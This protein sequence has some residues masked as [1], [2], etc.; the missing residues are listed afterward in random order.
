[1]SVVLGV[2]CKKDE[3]LLAVARDGELVDSGTLKLKA[4]VLLEETEGL[5]AMLE[6]I[7][8]VVAEVKPDVVRVLLP[9][10]TYE[11]SYKRIAPRASLETLVRLAAHRA[12]VP[13]ELLNR[14]SARARLGMPKSGKFEGHIPST[15]G[16]PVGKYWNA[17]RNLA[18][19]AA[20]AGAS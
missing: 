15:V 14:N 3:V 13:V 2:N 18:A 12:S 19:A 6:D 16:E 20:L 9:E 8:R 11:D 5:T 17:G 1:M 4:S 7:A 10:P